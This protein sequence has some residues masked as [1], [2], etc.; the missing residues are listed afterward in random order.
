[1]AVFDCRIC[2]L[3]SDK[4]VEDYFRWRQED[5][6]RNALNSWCYWEQRKRGASVRQATNALRRMP[7][8]EKLA[9]L[10]D[11]GID[12]DALPSWHKHGAGVYWESFEKEGTNPLTGE[13]VAAIRRR[14]KRDLDLPAGEAYGRFLRELLGEAHSGREG[15]PAVRSS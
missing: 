12:F 5:A 6:R 2:R 11:F 4:I 15:L 7:V 1:V 8:S 3:P 14:L 9:L 13:P 10:A